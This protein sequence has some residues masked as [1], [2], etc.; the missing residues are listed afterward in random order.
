MVPGTS[1]VEDRVD[2][3]RLV[4]KKLCPGC[5]KP[6][7]EHQFGTPHKDCDGNPPPPPLE[8]SASTSNTT[9]EPIHAQSIPYLQ[10][11]TSQ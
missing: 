3:A 2:P 6:L 7:G 4:R 1:D 5:K 10:K 8:T 9:Q 11:I